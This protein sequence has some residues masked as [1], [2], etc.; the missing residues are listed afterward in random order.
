MR[1]DIHRLPILSA[2][3]VACLAAFGGALLA[4]SQPI[5]RPRLPSI[6]NP[7][8]DIAT[9]LL[10]DFP[11]QATSLQDRTGQPVV[12]INSR[13]LSE[14][15][16]YGQF[17]MAHE[18]CHHTLGHVRRYYEGLGHLG[19]QPFYYIRP[20]LRQM[21]LDADSCAVKLLKGAHRTDAIEAARLTMSDFG[22]KPTGAY[23]P[24]GTERAENI[25]RAAA[26]P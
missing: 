25:A 26:E 8:C 24:T 19:P 7:Y 12:V 18:C 6:D 3:F 21:E 20:Q 10:P 4:G 11:E 2:L 13:T 17:L 15:P 5:Q 1:R 14:S 23:Y 16:D 9:F 22:D